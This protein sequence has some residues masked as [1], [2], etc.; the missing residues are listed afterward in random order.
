MNAEDLKIWV[1]AIVSILTLIVNILFYLFGQPRTAYKLK[2][3]EHFVEVSEEFLIYLSQIVSFDNFDGVPTEVRNYCLKLHLCFKTGTAP[4]PLCS[5]LEEIFQFVKTRK[6]ISEVEKI[7]EW[8]TQ[9]REKVRILRKNLAKY[10]G[11][12]K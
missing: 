11:T 12:F 5:L 2:I 1:P 9:F 4:E 10:C 6:N 7:N 3:K 8:N